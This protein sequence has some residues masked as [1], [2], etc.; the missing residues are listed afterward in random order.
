[1][2]PKYQS[3]SSFNIPHGGTPIKFSLRAAKF[4][5]QLFTKQKLIIEGTNEEKT[6][7]NFS[8]NDPRNAKRL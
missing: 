2:K 3:I 4:S 6:S 5:S 1:M 8:G 7:L